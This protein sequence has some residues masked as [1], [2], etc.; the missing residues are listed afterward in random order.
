MPHT[1]F[2]GFRKGTAECIGIAEKNRGSAYAFGFNGKEN[3]SEVKGELTP[4][5]FSSGCGWLAWCFLF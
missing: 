3:D 5:V 1:K 4:E 2:S